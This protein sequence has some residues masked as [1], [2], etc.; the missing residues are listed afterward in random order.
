L[1]AKAGKLDGIVTM[2]HDQ[3]QIATKLLGFDVGV[4]V[5]G[6]LPIPITTP[7]HGTAYDIVGQGI[8]RSTAMANAFE[9]A[10][11]N[12]GEPQALREIAEPGRRHAINR[13]S[14]GLHYHDERPQRRLHFVRGDYASH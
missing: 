11:R 3:G 2:Y 8:A 12:G 14:A 5:E 7:A 4:T 10:C 13:S 9:L 1:R 6:G